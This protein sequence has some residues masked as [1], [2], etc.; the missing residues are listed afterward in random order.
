MVGG[1]RPISVMAPG[2]VVSGKFSKSRLD[3]REGVED[4]KE[5]VIGPHLF[6]GKP[7]TALITP[8]E[9]HPF[10]ELV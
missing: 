6:G 1:G 3:L 7:F 2:G 9:T 4:T 10:M 8:L 5:K